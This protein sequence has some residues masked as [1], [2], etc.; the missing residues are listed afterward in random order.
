MRDYNRGWF[1][2]FDHRVYFPSHSAIYELML[3]NGVFEPHVR[4]L[5]A[6]L[7]RPDTHVFDVGANIGLM[8][9]PILSAHPAVHVTSIEPG[10]NV[11]KCLAE[12]RRQSKYNDRWTVI[13]KAIAETSGQ[14]TFHECLNGN[15]AFSGIRDTGRGGASRAIEVSA[16]RLDALWQELG[17]PVVSVIKIDVEGAELGVLLGAPECVEKNR[18]AILIEWWPENYSTYGTQGESLLAFATRYEYRV[19]DAV[20]MTEVRDSCMLHVC[21]LSGREDFILVPKECK[22]V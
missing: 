5:I 6:R 21:H 9:I 22:S 14:L 13:N 19:F 12:T 8:A 17:N 11:Y 16:V 3:N 4:N 20:G 10:P 2:Y 1:S 15:D 18:P 7:A